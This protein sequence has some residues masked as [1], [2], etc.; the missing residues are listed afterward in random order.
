MK[1]LAEICNE[2]ASDPLD[3]DRA[4]FW[5]WVHAWR[6]AGQIDV[7]RRSQRQKAL[8][9]RMRPAT[10]EKI[11]ARAQRRLDEIMRRADG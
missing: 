11:G 8:F 5:S 1:L 2:V 4:R 7:D 9:A 6:A 10:T 3:A